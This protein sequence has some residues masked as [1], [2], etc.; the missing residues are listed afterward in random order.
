MTSNQR[1][2]LTS[3]SA[4]AL[5]FWFLQCAGLPLPMLTEVCS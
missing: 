3:K 5:S 1:K 4:T 2:Q